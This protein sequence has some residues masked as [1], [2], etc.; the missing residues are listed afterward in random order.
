MNTLTPHT[1][2]KVNFD[3]KADAFVSDS[4]IIFNFILID[5]TNKFE[6]PENSQL[7][8]ENQI[9]IESGLWNHTCFEAFLKPVGTEQYYEFNFSFKPAWMV[10]HFERYRFP[11]PP[12][13]S[14]D[15]QMQSMKWDSTNFKLT[16]EITNKTKHKKFN[17]G[18]TAILE[19]KTG[20]KHYCALAHVGSKP[21]FHLSDSFTLMRG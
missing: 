3:L 5:P 21:D 15:F 1:S 13:T 20:I 16:V 11:Q 6:K 7:H 10:F 4:K 19:E 9:Q 8:I 14:H 18:L 12:T 17:I 2:E